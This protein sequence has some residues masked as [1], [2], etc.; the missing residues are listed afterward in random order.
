[1]NLAT[2]SIT[3]SR[4]CAMYAGEVVSSLKISPKVWRFDTL[5]KLS[6]EM[7]AWMSTG[8]SPGRNTPCFSPRSYRLRMAAMAGTF[9]SWMVAIRAL[10][11]KAKADFVP[12]LREILELSRV[13]TDSYV[14]QQDIRRVSSFYMKEWAG[15][16]PQLGDPP[17]K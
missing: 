15:V 7:E 10:R 3:F 13:R 1:M 5:K 8:S 4:R 6:A 12:E 14:M 2:I 11:E 16:E 17:P 9:S